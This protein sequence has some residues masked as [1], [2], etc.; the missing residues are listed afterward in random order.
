[1]ITSNQNSYSHVIEIE[2]LN[3]FQKETS[4]NITISLLMIFSKEFNL[5]YSK[6]KNYSCEI[7][8]YGFQGYY[9][10][11]GI[12]YLN[13]DTTNFDLDEIENEINKMFEEFI[14][15]LNIESYL[16]FYFV[17]EASIQHF[18]DDLIPE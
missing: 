3:K 9:P 11:I 12:K 14:K 6:K 15:T 16:E 5:N 4:F 2:C 8:K 13:I 1:M 18:I 17:S 10:A 7:I